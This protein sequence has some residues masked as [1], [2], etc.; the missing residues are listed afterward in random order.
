M[1]VGLGESPLRALAPVLTLTHTAG[2]VVG[3]ALPRARDQGLAPEV[4]DP[5]ATPLRRPAV[6]FRSPIR[7]APLA[8]P[9]R[10]QREAHRE[11]ER[12][13]DGFME[14]LRSS[15]SGVLE[16]RHDLE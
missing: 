15:S 14:R 2:I 1:T 9:P 3:S 7:L 8:A 5:E 11:T 13:E 12:M 10:W 16:Q 4:T 6:R